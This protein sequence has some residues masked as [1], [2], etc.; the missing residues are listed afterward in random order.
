MESTLS[1]CNITPEKA[2]KI[3]HPA[4]CPVELPKKF[5]NLYSFKDDLILDPFIGSGTTA[6][7]SKLLKRKY[8]GYEINKNYIEIANNRLKMETS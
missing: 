1:I 3:C 5:I 6:V 7:A 4:P 8:V 2:K